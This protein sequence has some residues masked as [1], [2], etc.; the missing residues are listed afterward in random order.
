MNR[1][2]G[3]VGFAASAAALIALGAVGACSGKSAPVDSG[4]QKDLAA[5][6]GGSNGLEL[7]PK[8]VSPQ[9]VVSAIEAGPTSAPAPA[10]RKPVAK[11]APKAAVHQAARV[12]PVPAPAPEP[13]IVAPAPVEPQPRAQEPAPR[14]AE[15]TPAPRQVEPPP[16]PPI[17]PTAH[18]AERQKGVYKTEGEI[19]Q[20]MPWI[21]PVR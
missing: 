3:R 10:A 14:Q 7:A 19:F 8:S 21:K 16:L 2:H 20:Q 1:A 6:S 9:L 13:K 17:A 12:A 15:A 11:P 18:G 5:A 4:L